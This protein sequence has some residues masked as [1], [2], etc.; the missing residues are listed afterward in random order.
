MPF[1]STTYFL[2]GNPAN[3]VFFVHMT[4][5]VMTAL[6]GHVFGVVVMAISQKFEVIINYFLSALLSLS[7]SV[8]LAYV[9]ADCVSI[10]HRF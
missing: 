10:K 2:A 9:M 3:L 6:L 5:S 8:S 1:A 7:R 4:L